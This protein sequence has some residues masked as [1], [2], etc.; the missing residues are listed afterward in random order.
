MDQNVE[1]IKPV[2]GPM[3]STGGIVV[4]SDITYNESTVT[5]SSTT[6]T[7]G[8]FSGGASPAPR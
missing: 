4:G 6:Q 3:Q 7:Y 2:F 5:Y 8:G 1:N